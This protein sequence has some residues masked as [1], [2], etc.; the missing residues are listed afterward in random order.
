MSKIRYFSWGSYEYFEHC[1]F[2]GSVAVDFDR[3]TFRCPDCGAVVAFELPE[4]E[5]ICDGPSDS[6][7]IVRLRNCRKGADITADDLCVMA[8]KT[9]RDDMVNYH[10][11]VK[12]QV[13]SYIYKSATLGK[14]SCEIPKRYVR[15]EYYRKLKFDLCA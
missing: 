3:K 7:R 12:E 15:V 13:W 9:T 1:P 4:R 8:Q 6:D 5:A 10:D 14:F 2:C 11:Y